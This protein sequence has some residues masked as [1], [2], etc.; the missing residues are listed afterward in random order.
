[1]ALV[2]L[3][4]YPASGKTTFATNLKER[5]DS[6]SKSTI[7]IQDT[8]TSDPSTPRASLYQTSTI[9]KTTR[10]RL[11][12]SV[13]RALTPSTIVIVDSLNYIKGYRYELFCIAKTTASKFCIVHCQQTPETCHQRDLTRT[14]QGNDAYG[15]DLVSALIR[16]F[17]APAGIVKWE[18]PLFRLSHTE[19]DSL[20]TTVQAVV[21]LVTSTGKSLTPTMATRAPEKLG[22]DVLAVVDRVTRHV[23]NSI[24]AALHSGAG[25]GQKI[26]VPN[27]NTHVRL[28]RKP[29]VSEVR[30]MRRAYINLARMQ[31]VNAVTESDLAD[32]YIEYVNAQLKVKP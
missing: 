5:L 7:V 13:E 6:T 29:K 11:R 19:P 31:P 32:E 22:S 9:E 18:R 24:V 8:N 21:D 25:I 12:A 2:L 20:Q 4:G 16:R 17:E 3:C 30:A 14:Q 27:A 23:E 10:A 28:H 1:M 15:A 26:F